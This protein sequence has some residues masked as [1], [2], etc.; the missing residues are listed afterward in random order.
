MIWF[1]D[2]LEWQ[3]WTSVFVIERYVLLL[4]PTS[5]PVK[6]VRFVN[7]S[8]EDFTQLTCLQTKFIIE[9]NNNKWDLI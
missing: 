4:K 8:K 3:L 7:W 2:S 5:T 6:P 9:C 1:D